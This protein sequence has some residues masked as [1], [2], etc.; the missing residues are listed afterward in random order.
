MTDTYVEKLIV[1]KFL[2]LETLEGTPLCY[3]YFQ[4]NKESEE[5]LESFKAF[6]PDYPEGLTKDD[7]PEVPELPVKPVLPDFT[8]DN[9]ETGL[10]WTEEEI[11]AAKEKYNQDMDEY[12][13]KRTEYNEAEAVHKNWIIE[14]TKIE[15][16]LIKQLIE[17][18]IEIYPQYYD[19]D[20]GDVEDDRLFDAI[21]A[22]ALTT[23]VRNVKIYN[24]E[25][26]EEILYMYP[27]VAFPNEDFNRPKD[28]LGINDYWYELYF[29]PAA[30]NQIELGTTGRS[31][32][33]GI[34]QINVC[35]PKTWGTEELYERYD[36]IAKLFRSGL[37]LEGVRIVRTYR[38]TSIDS[39]DYF[40]LPVTI[41]W[42]A[43][44]DR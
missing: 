13:E 7:E 21:K 28:D 29:I 38:S 18:F 37:I 9:P 8:K 22:T 25:G 12:K 32:W 42:Q 33:V 11:E 44:L 26:E 15:S 30:P 40:C 27:H 19:T 3:Q 34:M 24:E 10:P 2:E 20:D 31:R 36:E 35:L 14:R 5:P 23:K 39:D 4:D 43:D 17:W 1:D 6:M 16:P 41:E